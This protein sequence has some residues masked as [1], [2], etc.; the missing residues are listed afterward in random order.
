MKKILCSLLA[1]AI[2]FIPT[3]CDDTTGA[4]GDSIVPEGD[5]IIPTTNISYATSRTIMAKDSILANTSDVYLGQYTDQ[6]SGTTF[7]SG[8][9]TQFGCTED[10]FFP[11]NG[12]RR[13][14]LRGVGRRS[15]IFS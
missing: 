7:N 12:V 13:L 9:I 11:E 5:K 8:F 1:M 6:E 2:L 15:F 14:D 4:I 3:G 10:F